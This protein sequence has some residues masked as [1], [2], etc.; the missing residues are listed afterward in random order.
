M[1]A[2]RC[3]PDSRIESIQFDDPDATA[4]NRVTLPKFSK[5]K[6]PQVGGRLGR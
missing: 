4:I 1:T 6:S 5:N 2:L 3:Q